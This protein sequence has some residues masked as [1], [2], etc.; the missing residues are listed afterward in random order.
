MRHA[1]EKTGSE[2]AETAV[3]ERSVGFKTEKVIETIAILSEQFG[4]FIDAEI[5]RWSKVVKA[6]GASVD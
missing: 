4:S 6:S 1:V 2:P 3:S 5:A